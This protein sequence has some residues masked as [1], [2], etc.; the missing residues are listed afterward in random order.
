MRH[1]RQLLLTT[2]ALTAAVL[3]VLAVQGT[4]S[5]GRLDVSTAQVSTADVATPCPGT[6]TAMPA[7]AVGGSGKYTAVSV[8]LPDGC[9]GD[10]AVVLT[11]AG[12]AVGQGVVAAA[13]GTV[14]VPMGVQYRP[15]S[16]SA[17]QATVAGWPL[18]VTWSAPRPH[19]WCDVTD[20][21][22]ATCTASVT[23]R[24]TSA[25]VLYLDVFVTTTSAT[26]VPWS[27]TFDLGHEFY[28]LLPTRLGNSDLDGY[29]DGQ[30]TWSDSGYT[31]DVTRTSACSGRP[32]LTVAGTHSGRDGY[33]EWRGWNRVWVADP[34]WFDQVRQGRARQFSLVVN[35]TEQGYSDVVAP[36]CGW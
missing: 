2:A 14:E 1:H 17:V 31:N 9:S 35:R 8:T 22:G 33:Y 5:A 32:V 30:L 34:N 29:S 13:S 10:L 3:G 27:V 12:A 11:D 4:A 36:T 24:T 25:G 6:A 28:P 18:A 20:G 21:T 19:V 15:G 26:W 7:A 23:P 16:G